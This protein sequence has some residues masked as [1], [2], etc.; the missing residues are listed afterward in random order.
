[1]IQIW[2]QWYYICTIN[3]NIECL[4]S[5]G[6]LEVFSF[7]ITKFLLIEFEHNHLKKSQEIFPNRAPRHIKELSIPVRI[8]FCHLV[9]KIIYDQWLIIAVHVHVCE[10]IAQ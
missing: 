6:C 5:V 8:R 10:N 7:E 2:P 4:E 9:L 1:M 3:V